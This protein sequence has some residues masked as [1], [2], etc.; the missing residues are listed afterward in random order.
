MDFE[1]AINTVYKSYDSM[2]RNDIL[3]LSE[4]DKFLK[5]ASY[6][7]DKPAY[8]VY[9]MLLL[10]AQ[11]PDALHLMYEKELLDRRINIVPGAKRVSLISID[12]K[13]SKYTT[14]DLYDLKDTN[15]A[16][17]D[18]YRIP[19]TDPRGTLSALI[20]A[21]M[22]V[23]WKVTHCTAGAVPWRDWARVGECDPNCIVASVTFRDPTEQEKMTIPPERIYVN[24]CK[25]IWKSFALASLYY[26]DEFKSKGCFPNK[27]LSRAELFANLMCLRQ[28]LTDSVDFENIPEPIEGLKCP[29]KK[30]RELFSDV[31][32]LMPEMCNNM[33]Y[34]IER[35]KNP[36][37]PIDVAVPE[38]G[39]GS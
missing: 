13:T 12:E 5:I 37:D 15:C 17:D 6:W 33:D 7:G 36:K 29:L 14:F 28:Q 30:F 1:Q 34:W 24:Q 9:N 8:T 39:G 19:T 3:I 26:L 20:G 23:D 31:L 16:K 35:D 2:F 38:G 32:Y 22:T 18:F 10:K 21:L 4:L 25:A 27:Y 11:R